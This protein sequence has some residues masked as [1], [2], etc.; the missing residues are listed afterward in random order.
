M[1]VLTVMQEELQKG[2][3]G[4]GM[5]GAMI[6]HNLKIKGY[7][8]KGINIMVNLD[9]ALLLPFIHINFMNQY[10]IRNLQKYLYAA[11][12]ICLANGYRMNG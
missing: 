6:V 7:M 9:M 10:N 5:N 11:W 1:D 3:Q 2:L 12:L 4:M 8:N